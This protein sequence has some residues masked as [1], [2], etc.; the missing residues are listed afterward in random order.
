NIGIAYDA[1]IEKAK[2]LIIKVANLA[3]WI[4]K[5]PA[6]KVVVKNFGES[7][8][9]LQ[10]RVWINDARKRMDTISYIT[11]NVK[12]LFDKEGIEIPYPKRDI[13]IKHES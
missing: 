6:P 8:V 5:D 4:A 9:D 2:K 10:L 1:D 7:S 12:T 13:I 3:E 11:D